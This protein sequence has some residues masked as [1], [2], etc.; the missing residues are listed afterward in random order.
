MSMKII[1]IKLCMTG[2][3]SF[4]TTLISELPTPFANKLFFFF[5]FLSKASS[6]SSVSEVGIFLNR[7]TQ[8]Q[9]VQEEL[10]RALYVIFILASNSVQ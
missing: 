8:C 10:S 6:F 3:S 2:C 9:G 7:S 4:Q 1:S 5:F